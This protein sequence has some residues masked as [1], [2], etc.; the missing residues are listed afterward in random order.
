MNIMRK[1]VDIFEYVKMTDLPVNTLGD[2]N[3]NYV[4]VDTSY[5][6]QFPCIET[7]YDI[8]QLIYQ[9]NNRGQ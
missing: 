7:A 6:N 9:P 5:F 4:L 8:H 3:F 1:V 2:F